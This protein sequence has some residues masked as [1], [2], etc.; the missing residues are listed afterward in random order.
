M[1]SQVLEKDP[2]CL[3]R[4]RMFEDSQGRF[5]GARLLLC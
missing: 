2:T 4:R 5:L 3:L 1:S